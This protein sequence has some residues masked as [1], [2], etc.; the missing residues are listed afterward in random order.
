VL[1]P[2]HAADPRKCLDVL[3]AAFGRVLDRHPDARLVLGGGGN[4]S[5]AFDRLSPPDR[6]RISGASVDLGAGELADVPQRYAEA[7]VTVLPSVDEAFGLV[8]VE[9]LATGT[10]VVG[11]ASGGP[12]EIVDSPEIGRLAAPRDPESLAEAICATIATAA[13][14]RTPGRCAEHAQRWDWTRTIGPLHQE[15]YAQAARETNWR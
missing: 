13:D 1:F 9:S 8:L 5:W 3:L 2:A 6:V 15:V 14:P 4:T 12:L 7:T 11:V 10:P